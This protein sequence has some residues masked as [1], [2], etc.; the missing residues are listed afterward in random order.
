MINNQKGYITEETMSVTHSD[1]NSMEHDAVVAGSFQ[2]TKK[3]A[4]AQLLSVKKTK[5]RR[6]ASTG[7]SSNS[8]NVPTNFTPGGPRAWMTSSKTKTPLAPSNRHLEN[9]KSDTLRNSRSKYRT[10]LA[11]L[12]PKAASA[13]R[14][15]MITPK[16]QP[17]TPVALL[18]HA[19][20]GE[21]AF[22]AS[23]S[24]IV[25]AS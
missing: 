17:N 22:S 4:V 8:T 19:R 16:V 25:T 2:S 9:T 24:P 18:R 21:F 3:T 23:G 7:A 15:G 6:S 14:I 10:P 20:A 5:V 13:D 1:T 11:K 12:R